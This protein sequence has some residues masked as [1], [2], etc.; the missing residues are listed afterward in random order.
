MD[1][2]GRRGE[3]PDTHRRFRQPAA[4][5][6]RVRSSGTGVT[7]CPST[8]WRPSPNLFAA[9]PASLSKGRV[10]RLGLGWGG[11]GGV[12]SASARP[13]RARRPLRGGDRSAPGPW[14]GAGP[15]YDGV[16]AKFPPLRRDRS[17]TGGRPSPSCSRG[18]PRRR[19]PGRPDRR[20]ASPRH[21]P[22]E[23]VYDEPP[24]MLALLRS[25]AE[26]AGRDRHRSRSAVGVSAR[27]GSDMVRG[28]RCELRLTVAVNS[29]KDSTVDMRDE[30]LRSR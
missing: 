22:T 5:T 16:D 7:S 27:G 21:F 29:V 1:R 19:S 24:K 8:T 10:R 12:P 2:L 4:R 18:H 11:T 14:A 9:P 13:G 17:R 30:L 3:C 20:T 26:E 15:S 23:R 6:N 25:S 28:P